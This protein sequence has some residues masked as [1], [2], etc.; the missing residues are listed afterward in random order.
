MSPRNNLETIELI[1]GQKLAT[2]HR[3]DGAFEWL[4]KQDL[5]TVHR[6]NLSLHDDFKGKARISIHLSFD[7]MEKARYWSA[8]HLRDIQMPTAHYSSTQ[9]YYSQEFPDFICFCHYQIEQNPSKGV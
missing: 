9:S 8:K 1:R 3:V 4:A 7:S 6:F 5:D 2:M